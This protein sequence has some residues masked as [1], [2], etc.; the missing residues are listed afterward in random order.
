[1]DAVHLLPAKVLFEVVYNNDS[2]EVSAEAFKVFHMDFFL[3]VFVLNRHC[4]LS[5]EPVGDTVIDV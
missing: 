1:V 2:L 4:V 3:S 5:V